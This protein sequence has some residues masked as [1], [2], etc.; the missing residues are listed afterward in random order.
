[1]GRVALH[2]CMCAIRK[3]LLSFNALYNLHPF[4]LR[5][6]EE[7]DFSTK[8]PTLSTLTEPVYLNDNVNNNFIR[9]TGLATCNVVELILGRKGKTPLQGSLRI[10]FEE[11]A[12]VCA[13]DEAGSS[14]CKPKGINQIAKPISDRPNKNSPV[15]EVTKDV[16]HRAVHAVKTMRDLIRDA[17]HNEQ[18]TRLVLKRLK[19]FGNR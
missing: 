6:D 12:E 18:A 16:M 7:P 13:Q 17:K 3:R 11:D 5:W 10:F 14:L 1:M 4:W 19:S 15:A 2:S 8:Y 9:V